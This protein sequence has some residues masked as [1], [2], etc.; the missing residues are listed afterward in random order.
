M[1]GFNKYEW[2]KLSQEEQIAKS[3]EVFD[4]MDKRRSIRE[5]SEEKIPV[6]AVIN[7]IKT[8]S[9]APSGAHKQPWTF[10]LVSSKEIRTKIRLEAEEEEKLNYKQRMSEEWLDDLKKFQTNW[11]KPFL[12]KAPYLIVVFKKVYDDDGE[13]KKTNY[14][15]NE[16][17]GL[18]TGFLLMALHQVGIYALTHTP[19]PMKFL[20][21]ILKRPSNERAF[22]LIP[23]GYPAE[24]HE[25]PDLTRKLQNEIMIEYQ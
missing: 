24:G 21:K 8:A 17:V 6:N 18:A 2:T 11:E 13:G 4:F 5:F 9:T 1:K 3:E 7:A 23:I 16:S 19:S 22:L 14:Y 15:V 10:C 25:V 20:T 12:E